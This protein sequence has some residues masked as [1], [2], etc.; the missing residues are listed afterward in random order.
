[1]PVSEARRAIERRIEA[2]GAI[3]F[4]AF[5]DAALY[6]PG[7]YYATGSPRIGRRGDFI[8]GSRLG[9]FARTTH[10]LLGRLDRC[11]STSAQFLEVGFGDGRHLRNLSALGR[12]HLYAHDRVRRPLPEAV[13]WI[14]RLGDLDVRGLVLSYE[15]LDALPVRRVVRRGSDWAELWVDLVDGAFSWLER[16]LSSAEFVSFLDGIDA[17]EGQIVDVTD[18]WVSTYLRV[19]SAL[20]EGLLVT[21]DYGFERPQLYDPR[22]RMHGTLACYRG[23]TVHRDP[24]VDIG[25]QD[26]TAHVDFTAVREAGEQAGLA[27]V[28]VF[29]LADWLVQLGIFE[30]LGN[31]DRATRTEAQTLLDP[32]G[33]GSEIRVLV[34]S[35]GDVTAADLGLE[36][37]L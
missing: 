1:M 37:H 7:G 11:L 25:Q 22:V 27:T 34:Q 2:E 6:G 23:Q 20:E 5:M 21:C 4:S 17:V 3:P 10:N 33:M 16:P 13:M 36:S 26:L 35:R 18:E 12:D 14:D 9:L 30:F 8:T 29:K 32:A 15:L 24:F 28:G 31:V 19:G